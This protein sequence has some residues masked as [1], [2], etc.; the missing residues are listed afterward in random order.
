[1][2]W[3]CQE[4]PAQL[5][6]LHF[7]GLLEQ[8]RARSDEAIRLIRQAIELDASHANALSEL[9]TVLYAVGRVDEAANVYQ[10]WL[11]RDPANPLPLI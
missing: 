1:M 11:D 9:G 7:L 5:D 2:P 10:H 6:A 4:N 3:G 8:Q